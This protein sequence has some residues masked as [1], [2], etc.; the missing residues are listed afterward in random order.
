MTG[1][2][3][4]ITQASKNSEHDQLS[5][6]LNIMKITISTIWVI[7]TVHIKNKFGHRS[8]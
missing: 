8:F 3:G 2:K 4:K 6:E 1:E 5:R 7:Q